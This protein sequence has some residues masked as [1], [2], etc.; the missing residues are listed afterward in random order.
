M[1]STLR[2]KWRLVI[3][4][5]CLLRCSRIIVYI[6]KTDVIIRALEFWVGLNHK[7]FAENRRILLELR[8]IF[9]E[10]DHDLLFSIKMLS[11]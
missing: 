5:K 11:F 2:Q 10:F 7:P 3:M 8:E 6:V 9:L 4:R 1:R